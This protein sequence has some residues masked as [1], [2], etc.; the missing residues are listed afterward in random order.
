MRENTL[1]WE[2]ALRSKLISLLEANT[3]N[4]I[5]G[6]PSLEIKVILSR[7]VL[8]NKMQPNRTVSQRKARIVIHGFKQ[9]Y[10]IDY[11]ETFAS[12]LQYNT[13]RLLLA[14]AAIEDLEIKQMDV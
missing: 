4:I 5:K 2:A 9:T 7:L 11:F 10:G 1:E 12:V 6:K 14:K 8:R 13:L 3:F